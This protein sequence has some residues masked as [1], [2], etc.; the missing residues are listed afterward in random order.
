MANKKVVPEEVIQRIKTNY[1]EKDL[2]LIEAGK[3]E[4]YGYD[5]TRRIFRENGF[6][7]KKTHKKRPRVE[8]E[9]VIE[10]FIKDYSNGLSLSKCSKKYRTSGACLK[11][12]LKENNIRIRTHE[13]ARQNTDNRKYKINDDK[14]IQI[15]HDTAWLMG[16]IAADGY[17]CKSP[18]GK[19]LHRISIGLAEKDEEVLEKIKKYIEFDGPIY[20]YLKDGH[21]SVSLTFS[22]KKYVSFLANYGIT[23]KKT[24][25]MK[26]PLNLPKE[27][28]LD[29]IHGYFDGNGCVYKPND[30]HTIRTNLVSVSKENLSIIMSILEEQLGIIPTIIHSRWDKRSTVPLYYFTFNKTNS[31]KLYYGFYNEKILFLKRKKEK[32]ESCLFMN[33]TPTS[34]NIP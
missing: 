4:G 28:Y 29:F 21:P 12:I 11:K 18:E 26:F 19:T 20:H 32:F 24:Y 7:L 31:V 17:I 8:I 9:G 25:E 27:Y 6:E 15:N 1:Y 10:D 14:I 33:K 34:P 30:G 22:S 16:F 23:N 5:L 2:S 3:L 13:E